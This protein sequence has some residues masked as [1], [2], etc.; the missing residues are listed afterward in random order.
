V[1]AMKQTNYCRFMQEYS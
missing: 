1:K